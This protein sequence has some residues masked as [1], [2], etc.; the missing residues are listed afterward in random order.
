MYLRRLINQAKQ[1]IPELKDVPL[2][3][4]KEELR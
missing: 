1:K 3:R 2:P 4:Q